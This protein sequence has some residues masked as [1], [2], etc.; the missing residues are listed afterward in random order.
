MTPVTEK[1]WAEK[2]GWNE[3]C[4]YLGKFGWH[5][6]RRSRAVP[7]QKD[8]IRLLDT[9]WLNINYLLPNIIRNINQFKKKNWTYLFKPNNSLFL[10]T[11]LVG[12]ELLPQPRELGEVERKNRVQKNISACLNMTHGQNNGQSRIGTH[13]LVHYHVSSWRAINKHN[14]IILKNTITTHT[15]ISL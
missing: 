7:R 12:L 5:P 9:R 14:N 2:N 4:L 13:Y 8:W 15:N 10:S 1:L 3:S 11:F 6:D